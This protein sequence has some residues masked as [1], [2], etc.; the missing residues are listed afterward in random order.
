MD[1]VHDYET[2]ITWSVHSLVFNKVQTSLLM[3]K[4]NER[5]LKYPASCRQVCSPMWRGC[6]H[7]FLFSPLS[8]SCL[9]GS[10][11]CICIFS[12]RC[13][14][15]LKIRLKSVAEKLAFAIKVCTVITWKEILKQFWF[16]P[17]C[18]PKGQY[19]I[20]EENSKDIFKG[21][22]GQIAKHNDFWSQH[23]TEWAWNREFL[24]KRLLYLLHMQA[25]QCL[26]CHLPFF[27]SHLL[28]VQYNCISVQKKW[29]FSSKLS[30]QLSIYKAIKENMMVHEINFKSHLYYFK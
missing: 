23:S 22:Q 5:H 7:W 25:E 19:Q 15:P 6:V 13:N 4:V 17:W 3:A 29:R 9:S 20:S 11:F 26:L 16:T 2:A 21:K 30:G 28:H 18:I 10:S 24:D 1:G 12:K 14:T 8:I 27:S